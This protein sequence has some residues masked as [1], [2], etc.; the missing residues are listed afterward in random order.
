MSKYYLI[1]PECK[2][3]LRRTG[4]KRKEEQTLEGSWLYL[5][6]YECPKCNVLWTYSELRSLYQ[7]GQL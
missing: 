4:K 3:R 7:K 6:E 2:T 1:C 5:R